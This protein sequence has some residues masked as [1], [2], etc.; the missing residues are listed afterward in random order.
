MTTAASETPVAGT[1]GP[2]EPEVNSWALPRALVLLGG[3][4]AVV[5]VLAGVRSIA[6]LTERRPGGAGLPLRHAYLPDRDHGVRSDRRRA[7]PR[8]AV[9]RRHPTGVHLGCAV[10]HHELHP[11]R[12]LH[13]RPDP[14]RRAR[15]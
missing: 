6:W 1:P 14:A 5:I 15:P 8:R 10:V 3:T 13:H 12:R 9:D 4:A 11:Q 2:A 7:R